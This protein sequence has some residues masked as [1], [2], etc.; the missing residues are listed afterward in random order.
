MSYPYEYTYPIDSNAAG[1][2]G[3]MPIDLGKDKYVAGITEAA[4]SRALIRASIQRI[5]STARGERVMQP[6][7]GSDLRKLLFDP[8]DSHLLNEIKETIVENL[9][10]NEP[11]IIVNNVYL[12]PKYDEHTIYVNVSFRFK[13]NGKEETLDFAIR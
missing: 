12:N 7:F 13:I 10:K 4:D 2:S 8:L 5:L 6:E 1:Y 3:P 11:R 9:Q